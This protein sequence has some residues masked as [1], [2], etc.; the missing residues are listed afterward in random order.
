M[1]KSYCTLL[2]AGSMFLCSALLCG[3]EFASENVKI[4]QEKKSISGAKANS[5]L[6]KHLQLVA[7]KKLAP[8]KNPY[9]F[10][11]REKDLGNK[12]KWETNDKE[13]VFTGKGLHLQYAVIDFLE[14]QLGI[15]WMDYLNTVYKQQD[16]VTLKNTTGEFVDRYQ[17]HFI[18]PGA[19]KERLDWIAHTKTNRF[20]SWHTAHAFITWWHDF[21]KKYPQY[22]SL[23]K[24]GV[25]GP[26]NSRPH[27]MDAAAAKPSRNKRINHQVQLCC[28]NKDLPDFIIAQHM[29]SKAAS[30][31]VNISNNDDASAYCHCAE[32]KKLDVK[33]PG[34][35][36]WPHLSDRYLFL[37]NKVAEKAAKLPTPKKVHFL[38]YCETEEPPART[39]VA[40]NILVTFCP[41]DYRLERTL[42]QLDNWIRMGA[43]A[44]RMRPN[45]PCYFLSVLPVGFEKHAWKLFSETMKRKEVV[46]CNIDNLGAVNMGTFSFPMYVIARTINSPETP[47]E[48]W[49]EEYLRGYGK[50]AEDVKKYFALWR[51]NWE[52]RINPDYV[53]ILKRSRYFNVGRGLLMNAKQ[54]YK[55]EDFDKAESFLKDALKKDL[56]KEERKRV[57]ELILVNTHARLVFY[58]ATATGTNQMNHARKLLDF[59]KAN[60]V[61]MGYDMKKA[62]ETE[63]RWGDY[64]G[65]KKARVTTQ[66]DLPILETP[67]FWYFKA[68]PKQVGEKEKWFLTTEKEFG[69]WGEM[70][71]THTYW[72]GTPRM[73]LM[74]AKMKNS[75]PLMTRSDGMQGLFL[76]PQTGR[77]DRYFCFSVLWMKPAK[78]LSTGNLCIQESMKNGGMKQEHF[79]WTSLLPST[80]MIPKR[81]PYM[82]W[83]STKTAK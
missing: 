70:A 22:F 28:S 41:T 64:T 1:K 4:I 37:A 72:Q 61:L 71:A 36:E 56:T 51:N 18:W 79:L 44:I 40:P 48:V 82:L 49:E 38:A 9:K 65:I 31:E 11:L 77:I 47:F 14:K 24:N 55:K 8:G 33:R 30:R 59:R 52:K 83:S 25:R 7:G 42:V 16:K 69:K 54:Y 20:I 81:P 73:P 62:A 57:E 3:A 5:I 2:A 23:N 26:R 17:E 32:C 53:N 67:I 68:D 46:G 63:I 74:S 75:S 15:V 21:G 19:G 50:G 43:K 10:V 60:P 35:P 78:S 66:F 12:G 80:G 13:T 45:L 29:K 76:S 27:A 39:K 58:A 6:T 34:V